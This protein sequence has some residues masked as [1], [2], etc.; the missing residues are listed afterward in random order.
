MKGITKIIIAILCVL[1]IVGIC[2]FVANKNAAKPALPDDYDGIPNPMIEYDTLEGASDDV[3][4]NV[5]L[6]KKYKDL[7][8]TVF[9]ING[10]LLDVRLSR[11]EEEIATIRKARGTGDISGVY[12]EYAEEVVTE[13]EGDDVTLKGNEGKASLATWNTGDF[14]YSV[15][16][17]KGVAKDE[18][19]S[20]IKEIN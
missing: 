12:T 6:P 2:K 14:S 18:M 17:E 16:I 10:E 13:I 8:Q 4:F 1:L 19:I 20:M 3:G 11:D 9:V 7:A 5:T 15:Y